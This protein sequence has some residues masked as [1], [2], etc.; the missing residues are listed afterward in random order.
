[1]CVFADFNR[2]EKDEADHG[3]CGSRLQETTR[4]GNKILKT[5][6]K[7]PSISCGSRFVAERKK[8]GVMRTERFGGGERV[9]STVV[10]DDRMLEKEGANTY[11]S[12]GCRR[13]GSA[14]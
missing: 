13:R 1:M 3:P 6:M 14:P 9:E 10:V 12:C 7:P 8:G 4:W 5:G 2:S 11:S